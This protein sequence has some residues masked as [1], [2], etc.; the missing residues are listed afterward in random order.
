MLNQRIYIYSKVFLGVVGHQG[1]GKSGQGDAGFGD[2]KSSTGLTAFTISHDQLIISSDI[3]PESR[4]AIYFHPIQQP[5]IGFKNSRINNREKV[6]SSTDL[7]F[8][9]KTQ[10][11]AFGSH[12]LVS[13]SSQFAHGFL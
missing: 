12:Q 7:V 4:S 2:L 5:A 1:I 6:F 3:W 8:L 13:S 11:N 10:G 9:V